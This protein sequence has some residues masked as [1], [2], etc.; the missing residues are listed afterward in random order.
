LVW[1]QNIKKFLFFTGV[2]AENFVVLLFL[3]GRIGERGEEEEGEFLLKSVPF[4]F[5]FCLFVVGFLFV[6]I[7][8]LVFLFLL[9]FLSFIYSIQVQSIM[10]ILY[11]LVKFDVDHIIFLF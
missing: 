5:P 3:G 9:A 1:P 2:K 4:T 10:A 11:F 6:F 8:C 7:V